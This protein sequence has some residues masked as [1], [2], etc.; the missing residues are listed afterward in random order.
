METALI[1]KKEELLEAAQ[2]TDNLA[3]AYKFY[4]EAYQ[5]DELLA[6]ID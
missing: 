2:K 1:Q 5:I 6:R 4:A 3:E